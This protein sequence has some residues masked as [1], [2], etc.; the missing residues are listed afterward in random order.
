MDV[1]VPENS[2]LA[3]YEGNSLRNM[4]V[5]P[6]S[7][8]RSLHQPEFITLLLEQFEWKMSNAS[9]QKPQMCLGSPNVNLADIS[10]FYDSASV[11]SEFISL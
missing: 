11:I 2:M 6:E 4:E 7:K 3:V 5:P 1:A 8:D 9:L 10:S